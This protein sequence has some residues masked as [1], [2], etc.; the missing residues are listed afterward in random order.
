M[1]EK[2]YLRVVDLEGLKREDPEAYEDWLNC[3]RA[4]SL[5][6]KWADQGHDGVCTTPVF[7]KPT[8]EG[9]W[10]LEGPLGAA[11]ILGWN[12]VHKHWSFFEYDNDEAVA[13][14]YGDN[15]RDQ[16]IDYKP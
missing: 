13:Q 5:S 6:D 14:I 8:E 7:G 2:K 9:G 4:D 16:D 1:E 11:F 3:D 10:I 12:P 15:V